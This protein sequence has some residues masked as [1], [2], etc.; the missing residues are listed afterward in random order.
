MHDLVIRAGNVVDGTGAPGRTADVAIDDGVITAVGDVRDSGRREI[1][2]APAR[3]C[4]PV[5][6]RELCPERQPKAGCHQSLRRIR[7]EREAAK[8]HVRRIRWHNS[9]LGA[10]TVRC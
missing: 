7:A 1:A 10:R 8:R 4:A 2:P 3:S 5:T 9:Q 6:N